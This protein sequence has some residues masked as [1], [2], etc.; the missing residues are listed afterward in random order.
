MCLYPTT[1]AAIKSFFEYHRDVLKYLKLIKLWRIVN[2]NKQRYNTSYYTRTA[3]ATSYAKP[4]FLSKLADWFEE[5]QAMQG[6]KSQ[7][8]HFRNKRL[9]S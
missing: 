4:F 3:A 1:S 8:L 6:Y 7:N 2:N 9:P 5:Y